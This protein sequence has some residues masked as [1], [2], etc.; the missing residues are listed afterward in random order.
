MFERHKKTKYFSFHQKSCGYQ[1]INVFDCI[2]PAPDG[3]VYNPM[4]HSFVNIKTRESVVY[5][6]IYPES[7]PEN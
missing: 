5:E 6:S 1:P 2:Q 4:T 3:F 7:W